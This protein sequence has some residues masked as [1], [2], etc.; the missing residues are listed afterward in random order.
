[1]PEK[2]LG[3]ENLKEAVAAGISMGESAHCMLDGFQFADVAKFVEAA[4]RLPAAVKDVKL[5][6]PEFADLDDDEKAQLVEFV[7]A[8]LELPGHVDTEL[9]I[10]KGLAFAIALSDLAKLFANEE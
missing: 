1:M 10:E 5:C 6:L 7:E 4:K 9:A 2:K 3:F 8:D